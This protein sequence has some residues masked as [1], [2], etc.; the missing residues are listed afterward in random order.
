MDSARGANPSG[1]MDMAP[2]FLGVDPQEQAHAKHA[3]IVSPETKT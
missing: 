2:L 3:Q 1:A